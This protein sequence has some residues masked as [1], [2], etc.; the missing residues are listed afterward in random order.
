MYCKVC[1]FVHVTLHHITTPVGLLSSVCQFLPLMVPPQLSLC[2]LSCATLT[3]CLLTLQGTSGQSGTPGPRGA[4]GLPGERGRD[5]SSGAP[6]PRGLPVSCVQAL[7]KPCVYAH[8]YVRYPSAWCY[9]LECCT[10]TADKVL[11]FSRTLLTF[12]PMN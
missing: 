9:F 6:G 3:A 12:T 1:V 10:F 11:P 5:G 2:K 8:T 7:Q 4:V